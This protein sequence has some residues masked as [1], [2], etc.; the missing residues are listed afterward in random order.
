MRAAPQHL[1]RT[2]ATLRSV[3][4]LA[5]LAGPALAQ[6]LPRA[7]TP[8]EQTKARALLSDQ[9][10]CLG[11]HE[12]NG[13]GGRIGPSLTGIA[14]RRDALWIREKIVAPQR[15][16]AGTAMPAIPMAP[17]TRE[18]IVAYLAGV[19]V[20]TPRTV[21][22]PA[23]RNASDTASPAPSTLYARWCAAC[24]GPSGRGDGPNARYLPTRPAIHASAAQMGARSD[25][26]LF[27]AIAGGGWVMGKS[28]RMPAFGETLSAAEIRSLVRYIR[29][30][31]AC[32]GPA[33]ST[34][35]RR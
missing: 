22:A 13:E 16:V 19:R 29:T 9:L 21:A 24:H 10:P 17:R 28:P 2:Y 14:G 26:A 25:D 20:D 31:C 18:L 34:D 12:L 4:C 27:D 33:W 32:E 11:C 30:L 1:F 8:F 15:L 6:S 3:L 5:V 35:D 7:L 23:S